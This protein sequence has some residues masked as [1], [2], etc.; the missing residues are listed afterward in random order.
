LPGADGV[1]GRDGTDGKEGEPGPQGANGIDGQNGLDGATGADGKEGSAGRDGRDGLPGVQ[2]EKGL[3]GR[4]G[5]DGAAGC[6]GVDGQDAFGLDDFDVKSDDDGRTLVFSFSREG[7]EPIVR[8]VKTAIMLDRGVWREGSFDKGDAV[9][10]AG[11]SWVAQRNT[12]AKPDTLD[13]GWRLAVKRGRDGKDGKPGDRGP[14][15]QQ[16]KAGRDLTQVG[17]D[18]AKW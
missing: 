8:S 14:E 3:D 11:S 10:W 2:G 15:G 18:G 13:S 1:A 6:N 16:G 5:V 9:T 17:A 12:D 4:N 7:R